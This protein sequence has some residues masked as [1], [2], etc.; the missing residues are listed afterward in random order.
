MED[1][2]EYLNRNN[3]FKIQVKKYKLLFYPWHK[4]LPPR[5][6]LSFTSYS[7]HLVVFFLSF[8]SGILLLYRNMAYS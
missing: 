6:F 5:V 3:I 7:L 8:F 1:L 4:D 2:Q